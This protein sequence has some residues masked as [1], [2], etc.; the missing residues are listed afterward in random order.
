MYVASLAASQTPIPSTARIRQ[1]VNHSS[2]L[3]TS[4]PSTGG[5]LYNA[6]STTPSQAPAKGYSSLTAILR[7]F[8]IDSNDIEVRQALSVLYRYSGGIAVDSKRFTLDRV[9][10]LFRKQDGTLGIGTCGKKELPTAFLDPKV[11]VDLPP[12]FFPLLSLYLAVPIV[13]HRSNHPRLV[14]NFP[15][16]LISNDLRVLYSVHREDPLPESTSEAPTVVHIDLLDSTLDSFAAYLDSSAQHSRQNR[17]RSL[18]F[19]SPV[20]VPFDYSAVPSAFATT[21]TP[22]ASSKR[23]SESVT[24]PSSSQPKRSKRAPKPPKSEVQQAWM[25]FEDYRDKTIG[26]VERYE[27]EVKEMHA[28]FQQ[29]YQTMKGV[30]ERN[31]RLSSRCDRL[32]KKLRLKEKECERFEAEK[33]ELRKLLDSRNSVSTPISSLVMQYRVNLSLSLSTSQ[34]QSLLLSIQSCPTQIRL[35]VP[36]PFRAT[37]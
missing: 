12:A 21:P 9:K 25:R 22:S 5:V 14:F 26:E 8:G 15:R 34:L 18:D 10:M 20:F 16:S 28:R 30:D 32:K 31:T 6:T 13:L 7:Q 35:P 37:F 4:N 33:E 3:R 11:E 36:Q 27:R 2:T 1:N 19:S 23:S 29:N 17:H 24:D